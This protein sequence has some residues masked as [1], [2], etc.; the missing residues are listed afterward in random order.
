MSKQKERMRRRT[1]QKSQSRWLIAAGAALIVIVGSWFVFSNRQSDPSDP[2]Q[3]QP[4]SKLS[5][6]DFHSL[7]FSLTEPE[8]VFFGHHGGLLVSKNGGKDWEPTTLNNADAMALGFPSADPQIMYAAGHDVFFKSTDSG[9]TWE[10]VG[11]NLPGTDIHGFTVNPENANQVFAHIV[12]YGIFGSQDGGSTWTL[13]SN[14]APPSTFNLAVGENSKSLYAAAGEAGLWQSQ[15]GGRTWMLIQNVPDSGAVAVAYIPA[16]GRFYVTTLGEV[17]GLY[18]S[19]DNGQTW[20][21]TGL[22]GTFLAVAVSPLD[23]DHVI[24]VNDQGGVF[25]S[26][27]GGV[28]WSDK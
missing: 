20:K 19:D 3:A 21:S 22:N 14:S 16:T 7:A 23:S 11:T 8:T 26:R 17:A 1:Q 2:P 27:D 28:S 12:G 13:L 10:S 4:I 24:A 6:A 15:D 18:V 9:K 25:A 5:T